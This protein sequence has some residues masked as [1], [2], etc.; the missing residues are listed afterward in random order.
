MDYHVEF[1]WDFH[2]T[3]W[4]VSCSLAMLALLLSQNVFEKWCGA[5]LQKKPVEC[6]CKHKP[7]TNTRQ[8]N[9]TLGHNEQET[10]PKPHETW[11]CLKKNETWKPKTKRNGGQK[12][13]TTWKCKCDKRKTKIHMKNMKSK[14]KNKMTFWLRRKASIANE[15]DTCH[16]A[17]WK[18]NENLNENPCWQWQTISLWKNIN[19][20][21]QIR[22]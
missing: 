9:V 2:V 12:R 14:T 22:L 19:Q 13:L 5:F 6:N 10:H 1:H 17:T 18:P 3:S 4:H 7:E 8:H 11:T 16:E 15:Q 21:E 20:N